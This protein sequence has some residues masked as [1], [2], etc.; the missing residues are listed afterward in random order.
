MVV[1]PL[2]LPN[3][4]VDIW[5]V[6]LPVFLSMVTVDVWTAVQRYQYLYT[7]WVFIFY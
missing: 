4:T 7:L 2:F 1:L 6:G 3:V 5:M